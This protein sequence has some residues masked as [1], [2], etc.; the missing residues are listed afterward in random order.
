[1][2]HCK[3]GLMGVFI[4]VTL[5]LNAQIKV[6]ESTPIAIGENLRID[7]KNYG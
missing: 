1:M 4:L 2:M 3:S 5:S 6:L 7:S